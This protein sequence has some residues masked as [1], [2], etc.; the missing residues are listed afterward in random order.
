MIY[1]N[2]TANCYVYL[3]GYTTVH[4]GTMQDYGENYGHTYTSLYLNASSGYIYAKDL[5]ST[6]GQ[7]VYFMLGIDYS[8]SGDFYNTGGGYFRSSQTSAGW[9]YSHS[10][11]STDRNAYPD[12]GESGSYKYVYSGSNE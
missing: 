2:G 10:V 4:R 8:S 3:S 12:N 7:K 9:V 11:S 6:A 5:I 1:G